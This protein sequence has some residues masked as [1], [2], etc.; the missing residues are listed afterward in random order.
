MALFIERKQELSVV[1]FLKSKFSSTA[2]LKIEDEFPDK[3]ISLPTISVDWDDLVGYEFELGNSKMLQE[4]TWYIDIFANT[5]EQ[6][7]DFAYKIFN[8]LQEGVPVYNYD[9]GFPPDVTP[10]QLGCLVPVSIKIRKMA[11]IPKLIDELYWR[12]TVIMV[13]TY[14]KP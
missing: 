9:E 1:Y 11:I 5:K 12:A 4:R 2:F 7:K 3:L 6:R 10:T 13:A 8:D 14:D